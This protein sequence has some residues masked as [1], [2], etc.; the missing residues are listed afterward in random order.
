MF[1]ARSLQAPRPVGEQRQR[2]P[3]AD[4]PILQDLCNTCISWMSF[5]QYMQIVMSFLACGYEMEWNAVK[6]AASL[7]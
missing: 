5:L 4:C 3:I 7:H 1:Q 6:K 2:R